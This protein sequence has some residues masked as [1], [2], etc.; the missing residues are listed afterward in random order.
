VVAALVSSLGAEPLPRDLVVFGE[1]GLTG[2]IR[3]VPYGEERLRE[4]AKHG[5]RRAVVPLANA[6]RQAP[7]GIAVAAVP[8]IADALAALG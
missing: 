1:L 7:E 6:P 8:T 5:F 4:A 2:E 3:P